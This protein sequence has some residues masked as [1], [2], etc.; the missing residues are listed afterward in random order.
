MRARSRTPR[1]ELSRHLAAV[2]PDVVDPLAAI[3]AGDVHV[4][5]RIVTNPRSLVRR[6]AAVVV[7]VP[8]TLRGEV[9][10]AAALASFRVAVAGR[11]ALDLGASAG[12]FTRA[13]LAA[14]ARR[15]Y[16][17]DAGHGQLLG[18]LRQDARVVSLEGT[19]LA[20]LDR[21]LAP[22]VVDVVTM[23]FSYLAVAAAVGQIGRLALAPDADL[24]ALVKPMFELGLGH[25][26]ED[27]DAL[28]DALR[29]ATA[30]VE[31]TGW[32]VAGHMRSPVRGARGA[33]EFL[34]HARRRA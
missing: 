25:A 21:R 17:V 34:V 12:G 2:R 24:V 8:R 7:R 27:P 13:L 28:D 33:V 23:D 15:V 10:L 4:D 1:R 11:I 32:R 6:D 26:P 30:G 29:R 3:A 18:S 5:G 19:N 22:D 16:A 14:G 20:A 9:K 31:Y